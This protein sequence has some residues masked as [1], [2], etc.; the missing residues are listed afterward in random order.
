MIG[1]WSA[2]LDTTAA[3]QTLDLDPDLIYAVQHLGK[4]SAG[5]ADTNDVKLEFSKKA[6][7]ADADAAVAA[8]TADT[9]GYILKSDSVVAT[10]RGIRQIKYIR[11]AGAPQLMVVEVSRDFFGN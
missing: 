3:S 11:F 10:K 2:L 9:D 5:A 4:D 1:F 7:G 8:R 6:N